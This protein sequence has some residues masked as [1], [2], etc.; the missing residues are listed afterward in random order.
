MLSSRVKQRV[1]G[2]L[3]LLA[4]AVVLVPLIF[5]LEP[6]NPVD[7]T[8]EIPLAPDIEAAV[9]E[10]PVEPVVDNEVVPSDQVFDLAPPADSEESAEIFETPSSEPV[11]EAA[12]AEETAVRVDKEQVVAATKLKEEP[13]QSPPKTLPR[14]E[15]K[16]AETGLPEAW[17]VQ[18]VSYQEK[19]KAEALNEK[20]QGAG[21]KSFVRSASV[22]G[23]TVHRVFVGPQILR[24]H[25]D[26]EKLRIDRSLGV[27]SMVI[28]FEP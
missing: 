27:N 20:L 10:E 19:P 3:V 26:E 12:A 21:F 4:L 8:T 16:V 7:Q 15:P 14:V 22:S 9:I 1:V 11:T 23:R 24:Q 5:D 25:A 13:L 6:S 2:S 17:V 18:V 28:P